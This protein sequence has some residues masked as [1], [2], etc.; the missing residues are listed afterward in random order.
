VSFPHPNH[1]WPN[2]NA[3]VLSGALD[4]QKKGGGLRAIDVSAPSLQSTPDYPALEPPLHA[5]TSTDALLNSHLSHFL[6]NNTYLLVK[7]KSLIYKQLWT[8][9]V[10]QCCA[11]RASAC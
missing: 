4:K 1:P 8:G 10:L 7:P 3:S 2:E 11:R 5:Q 9:V 6:L